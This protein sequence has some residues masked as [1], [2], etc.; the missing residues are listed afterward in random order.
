[1]GVESSVAFRL[2]GRNNF[3]VVCRSCVLIFCVSRRFM[4]LLVWSSGVFV[5]KSE[6][7]TLE[8]TCF[9][10]LSRTA[11]RHSCRQQTVEGLGRREKNS[12]LWPF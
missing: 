5:S 2:E 1:M 12:R 10:E 9:G 8:E 11:R 6:R 7:R 3:D 4:T